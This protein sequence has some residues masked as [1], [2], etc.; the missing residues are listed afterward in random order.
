VED[1]KRTP[2]TVR[3]GEITRVQDDEIKFRIQ[4]T[5]TGLGSVGL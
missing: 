1:K 4:V 5:L 3:D 2:L